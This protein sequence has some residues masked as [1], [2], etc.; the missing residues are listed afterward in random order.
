MAASSGSDRRLYVRIELRQSEG[1]K[2]WQMPIVLGLTP[3]KRKR[4]FA[5]KGSD[6]QNAPARRKSARIIVCRFL[7]KSALY[8]KNPGSPKFEDGKGVSRRCPYNHLGRRGGGD[9]IHPSQPLPPRARLSLFDAI[10]AQLGLK[11]EKR[12]MPALTIGHIEQKQRTRS[13]TA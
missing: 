6:R 7:L 2:M 11:M 10:A 8:R 5:C 9:A 4:W 3:S 1:S 13:L 12:P